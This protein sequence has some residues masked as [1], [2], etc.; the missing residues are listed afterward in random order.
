MYNL[1][2][3]YRYFVQSTICG[4]HAD[5]GYFLKQMGSRQASSFLLYCTYCHL[6]LD[7]SDKSH[8]TVPMELG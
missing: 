7:L 4:I 3:R 2:K 8:G 5:V 1:E 6:L